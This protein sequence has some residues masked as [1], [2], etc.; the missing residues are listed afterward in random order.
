MGEKYTP[1]EARGE[2]QPAPKNIEPQAEP[3]QRLA[4]FEAAGVQERDLTV[5]LI[6]K[7]S[8]SKSHIAELEKRLVNIHK[9][10]LNGKGSL[11]E[12]Q[13]AMIAKINLEID[14]Q[15]SK[16][17]WFKEAVTG[18]ET[19]DVSKALEYLREQETSAAEK[20]REAFVK[21]KAAGTKETEKELANQRQNIEW[22]Q[23]Q[24]QELEKRGM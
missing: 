1:P 6:I 18:M 17:K 21:N 2:V 16:S 11:E 20:L 3:Q 19:G 13:N 8:K 22:I 9:E 12:V 14:E 10:T 7:E 5:E 23:N 4:K 15:K 24:K